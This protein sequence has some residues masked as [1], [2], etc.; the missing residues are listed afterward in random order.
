[1]LSIIIH[2]KAIESASRI[3]GKKFKNFTHIYN[4]NPMV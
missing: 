1:M 2:D 3:Y 4:N